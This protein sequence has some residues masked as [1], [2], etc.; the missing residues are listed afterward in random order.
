M[1]NSYYGDSSMSWSMGLR[2]SQPRLLG[3][4]QVSSAQVSQKLRWRVTEMVH[5]LI[6]L[7]ALAENL[8]LVSGSKLD[9]VLT[10]QDT[11]V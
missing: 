4:F 10:T 5:L 11:F 1:Y 2:A 9:S 6:A 3:K 7:T 8:D